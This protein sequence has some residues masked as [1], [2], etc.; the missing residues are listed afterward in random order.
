MMLL[1]LAGSP[2]RRIEENFNTAVADLDTLPTSNRVGRWSKL[3]GATLGTS[4]GKVNT[5]STANTIYTLEGSYGAFTATLT[6][7]ASSGGDAFYFRV[8][9]ANNWFRVREFSEQSATTST[10]ETVLT[11]VQTVQVGTPGSCSGITTT[12]PDPNGPFGPAFESP[13]GTSVLASGNWTYEFLSQCSPQ[14]HALTYDDYIYSCVTTTSTTRFY[15]TVLEQMT[16]GVITQLNLGG[17]STTSI[18]G[19]AYAALPSRTLIVG[20]TPSTI[21]VNGYSFSVNVANSSN[22]SFRTVGIGRGASST[23]VASG[24]NDFVLE[25]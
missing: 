1:R 2:L 24:L 9:D 20:V 7:D 16:N 14:W 8:A 4:G 3:T 11:S 22:S 23:F 12:N 10:T 15:R 21:T 25:Y 19:S 5:S 18:N 13:C 6:L 17:T